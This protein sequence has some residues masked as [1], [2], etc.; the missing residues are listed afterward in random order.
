MYER[1]GYRP[2]ILLPRAGSFNRSFGV[3]KMISSCFVLLLSV[4]MMSGRPDA[5]QNDHWRTNTAS[6]TLWIERLDQK[7]ERA[8]AFLICLLDFCTR[9]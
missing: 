5:E 6:I 8:S 4:V 2:E 3:I 1:T 9:A 7:Q